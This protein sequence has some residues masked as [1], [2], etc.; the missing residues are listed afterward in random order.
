MEPN[1]SAKS[2]MS[3]LTDSAKHPTLLFL[4][5]LSSLTLEPKKDALMSLSHLSSAPTKTKYPMEPPVSASMDILATTQEFVSKI[6]PPPLTPPT[7]PLLNVLAS[8][9]STTVP[10]A[11]A[12]QATSA[13]TPTFVSDPALPPP[14]S[15][16][17]PTPTI[18]V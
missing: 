5:L 1:A 15:L 13:A 4:S 6:P 17:A 8:T 14:P 3:I 12:S 10:L 9:K 2:A 11:S 7:L 16:A 18:M